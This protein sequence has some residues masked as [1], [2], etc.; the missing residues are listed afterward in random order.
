MDRRPA[1]SQIH[2]ELLCVQKHAECWC[3]S[4]ISHRHASLPRPADSFAQM[5]IRPTRRQARCDTTC[6]EKD[7][8]SLCSRYASCLAPV[9]SL[10]STIEHQSTLAR[11]SP[12]CIW[13][14]SS[15]WLCGSSGQNEEYGQCAHAHSGPH[16]PSNRLTGK[17]RRQGIQNKNECLST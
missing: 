1:P 2:H 3:V 9:S 14:R 8:S 17:C 6:D 15:T 12:F 4:Y 7:G 13:S 11:D 16:A 10:S 5:L